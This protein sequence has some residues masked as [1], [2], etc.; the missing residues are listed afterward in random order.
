M[1]RQHGLSNKERI[2]KHRVINGECWETRLTPTK[3]YPTLKI[4]GANVSLHRVAYEVY[5]GPI[6]E[7]LWVLHSCD[8]PRCHRPKHL[9]LGTRRD[10][11]LDMIAKGRNRSGG[12]IHD[13]ETWQLIIELRE[14]T[15][16]EIAAFVGVSQP[17]V[18]TVL[19]ASGLG[20]GRG[21]RSK[22]NYSK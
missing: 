21:A 13:Q 11:I 9:F 7:G 6:P 20:I 10:N 17:F 16:H 14:F 5:V 18:S 8:N 19:C 12:P 3:P 4:D 2:E 22:K 15:Q 1:K